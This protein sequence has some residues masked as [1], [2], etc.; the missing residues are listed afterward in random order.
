MNPP[1]ATAEV[2]PPLLSA[3]QLA[4]RRGERLLFRGLD[5]SLRPGEIVWLQGRNGRGKTTLLRMLSGLS[6]PAEG[7]VD[8]SATT[9]STSS[10]S[11][12]LL[13]LG[14]ANAV[15]EDLTALES[16]RFLAAIRGRPCEDEALRTALKRLGI[17]SRA[18]A[19][20]RTLSQGQRRR[21][22]LA[23]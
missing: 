3:R 18:Q 13:Y 4:A 14:H 22:S 17:A 2:T 15:K 19:L 23:R 6:S 9:D 20:V 16:L 12:N 11:S 1:P 21:V 8:V 5:L 10:P 7:H